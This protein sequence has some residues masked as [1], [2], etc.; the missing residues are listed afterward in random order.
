M[1]DGSPTSRRAAARVAVELGVRAAPGIMW[2]LVGLAVAG[3]LVPVAAAWLM[4]GVLDRLAAGAGSWSAVA[5]AATGLAVTGLAGAVQPHLSTYLQGEFGRRT[6]LLAQDRLYRAVNGYG[7]L[8]RFE[9]AAFLNRLRLAQQCGQDS[10]GQIMGSTL[11]LLRA[12]TTT[13]GFLVSLLLISPGIAALVVLSGL[14][15]LLGELRLARARAETTFKVTSIERRELFYATLLGDAHAAKEVRLFGLGDHLRDRMHATRVS[16]NG[17]QR[18]VDR[19]GLLVQGAIAAGS[20]VV[21][22]VGLIW[23]VR[24]AA[25]GALS[26][27]DISMFV[28]AVAAAQGT[29][30]GLAAAVAVTHHHLLIFGHYLAVVRAG[31]DLAQRSGQPVALPELRRG[32]ELRD[33]WFRYSPAH[34]W[35]LRGVTMTIPHGDA[36]ALVGLNGAGKSTLVKLLCRFYDPSRGS[37]RWDGVDIREVPVEQL[38][39]R[40]GAIFQDYVEYDMTAAENI[41]VGDLAADRTAVET[42]AREVGIHEKLMSLP[43]GYDTMLSRSFLAADD[44]TDGNQGVSLSGGQWQ[45]LALA[46]VLLRRRRCLL[47]LDEPSAGLDAEAE[48]EI[49]QRLG[50]HRAGQTSLLI[51]HRLGAVRGADTIVVLDGGV[52]VE[53]GSHDLL[54]RAGGRYA[55][56]FALQADGYRPADAEPAARAG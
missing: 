12:L 56:L 11:G 43:Y 55:Q 45:R 5:V 31:S 19:R 23:A 28:A 44:D 24:A 52:V 30:G 50:A 39:A 22:A 47:I 36:V 40:L 13:A 53:Q 4:K 20:A 14:P 42:A 9:D 3:S 7:G 17:L 51:S 46:R 6:S 35:V 27:G 37:I 54:L 16:I 33:V 8:G 15:I 1:S 48:A 29:V 2:T 32:I 25:A 21:A 49:H 41:A 18:R 34:P 26:V 38:R 10:P